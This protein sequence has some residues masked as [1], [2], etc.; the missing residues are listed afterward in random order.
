MNS[1]RLD[2]LQF[3]YDSLSQKERDLLISLLT[4]EK[5]NI[6]IFKPHNTWVYQRI[7]TINSILKALGEDVKNSQEEN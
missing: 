1:Y 6:E 4:E 7:D 5:E 2:E 3:L